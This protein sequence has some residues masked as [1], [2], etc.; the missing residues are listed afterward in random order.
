MRTIEEQWYHSYAPPKQPR[1]SK[2]SK[3]HDAQPQRPKLRRLSRLPMAVQWTAAIDLAIE[4]AAGRAG[5][6][7]SGQILLTGEQ[8]WH[9]PK[10]QP[11]LRPIGYKSPWWYIPY[12]VERRIFALH[13]AAVDDVLRAAA[14][15]GTTAIDMAAVVRTLS[16]WR[17]TGRWRHIAANA[18]KQEPLRSNISTRTKKSAQR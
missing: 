13:A 11:P 15:H 6:R 18:P 5:Y 4:F 17:R 14:R 8:I 16:R 10:F 1:P 7:Q 2:R 12:R 9:A 3:P